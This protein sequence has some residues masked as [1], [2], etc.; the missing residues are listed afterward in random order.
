MGS[1]VCIRDRL[2]PVPF[3]TASHVLWILALFKDTSGGTNIDP[4][5]AAIRETARH[6][7]SSDGV[8]V[9][10]MDPMAMLRRVASCGIA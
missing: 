1:E 10:Q 5:L 8:K 6:C 4:D 2:R 7:L 3:D 9:E